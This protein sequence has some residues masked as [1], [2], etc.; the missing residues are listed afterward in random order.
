MN[1]DLKDLLSKK[2]PEKQDLINK[3]CPMVERAYMEPWR[4]Y[5]NVGHI[6]FCFKELEQ[7]EKVI[8]NL[9]VCRIALWYHDVIYVPGSLYNEKMS[10]ELAELHVRLLAPDQNFLGSIIKDMIKGTPNKELRGDW[11]YFHDV[12]F[13]IL[14]QTEKIYSEYVRSIYKE[15]MTLFGQEQITDYRERFLRKMLLEKKIFKS[16]YFRDLYEEKARANIK[17]EQKEIKSILNTKTCPHLHSSTLSAGL[18]CDDCGIIIR[19][20]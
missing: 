18:T 11:K 4:Y 5:H 16:E 9:T 3:L 10:G 19:R 1:S 2:F 17:F 14:G 15:N 7:V 12:D 13:S 6:L 8:G 20:I